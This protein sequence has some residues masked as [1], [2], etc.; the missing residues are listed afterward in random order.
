VLPVCAYARR[1]VAL[2]TALVYC[3]A[4]VSSA[5]DS[6]VPPNVANRNAKD[7]RELRTREQ[8]RDN[9]TPAKPL[10]RDTRVYRYTSKREAATL[11]R[12]GIPPRTHMTSRGGA[13]HPPSANAAQRREGLQTRP[14]ARVTINVPAGTLVKKNRVMG[15]EPG[16]GEMTAT[17]RLPPSNVEKS[18][19]LRPVR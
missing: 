12:D 6:K 8:A 18:V 7:W 2:G 16:R 1:V 9:R 13:G 3:L 15:G 11:Q 5:A 19:P 17:K 14:E 10:E 4:P